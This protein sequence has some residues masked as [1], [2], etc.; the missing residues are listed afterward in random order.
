MPV[1]VQGGLVQR[2]QRLVGVLRLAH[3]D[4]RA[5][6]EDLPDGESL[7]RQAGALADAPRGDLV[8]GGEQGYAPAA[9]AVV[10]SLELGRTSGEKAR[11]KAEGRGGGW[12]C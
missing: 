8:E 10:D 5:V 1:I 4:A 7:E 3:G 12:A 9:E 2:G 11:V 6:V